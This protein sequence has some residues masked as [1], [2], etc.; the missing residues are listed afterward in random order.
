MDLKSRLHEIY[1]AKAPAADL[2]RRLERL[3]RREVFS[4]A[5]HLDGY[6]KENESGRLVRVENSLPY[7]YAHGDHS[8]EA[9]YSLPIEAG[10][11]LT[12][13][14]ALRGF[15]AA[16]A[17]FFDTE[18]TG[19]AGGAG[20]CPFLL[21]C[22][23]LD[24]TDFRLLQFF[25]PDF[26]EEHAFLQ[27]FS[28]FVRT[29]REERGLEYLVTYNGKAF[30]MSLL[31]NRFVLQRLDS[32]C[33]GLAH[34]DLLHPCR[35]LW[36]GRFE[37]CSLQ[38][39]ERHVLNYHRLSDIPSAL[40]PGMYF[41]FLHWG[42]FG[43]LAEVLEHNRRD[44][45]SLAVLLGVSARA[46]AGDPQ[47]D[48]VDPSALARFHLRRGHLPEAAGFLEQRLAE[49]TRPEERRGLL[50]ELAR[51]HKKLGDF[52]R[53]LELCAELLERDF[54]PAIEVFEEAAKVLEHEKR[55]FRRA[56]EIVSRALDAY[57]DSPAL[58]RRKNRLVCRLEG[59]R[60]Y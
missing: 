53:A 56:L 20:T 13:D 21:G 24:G 45:I 16:R 8:L 26:G 36:R 60:W 43:A 54:H 59:R 50:F 18:T 22:G 11:T 15:D 40:I 17:L 31:D 2:R 37:D 12:G 33:A 55:D 58:E 28:E 46:L 57:P 7:F 10:A 32:P 52:D 42:E 51:L 4:I 14:S 47:C 6:W 1:G 49:E 27:D 34:L 19:L 3:H 29:L 44:I 48:V 9:L 41:N 35:L 39:L 5:E 23:Y 25:L 30:D 38:T